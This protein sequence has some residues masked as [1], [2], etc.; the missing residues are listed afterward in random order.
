MSTDD[1][2]VETDEGQKAIQEVVEPKS[3]VSSK[4]NII[5]D[6]T[7]L[8][9]LMGCGRLTNFSFNLNLQ[10][11]GGKSN[12]LEVGSI[13]HK[14]LEVYYK[15]KIG[16]MN[17]SDAIQHGMAAGEL[18]IRGCKYCTD[19]EP[20]SELPK[21][22]CSHPIN[23]YPGVKNTPP[24]STTSPKNLVGWR[25]ALDT[26]TQYFDRW[27]NDHWVPIDIEVVKGE[28]LYE[29]DNIR[30]LWKAKLD[31]IFD[32]NQGIYPVDHKTSKARRKRIKLNN[33][34]KGQCL[35]MKTRNVFINSIGFQTSLK[36]EEK[37][38]REA[39]SYSAAS[40]LEW[41]G[42]IL[43]Y[44]A[45]QLLQFA[46]SG[47]WPPNFDHCETKYG[48]CKFLQ[49]CEADPNMREEELKLHYVVGPEW[50]PTN[51]ED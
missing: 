6:A 46:E 17:T 37:F 49:V 5:F 29:D 30:I 48:T 32:T 10:P 28:I 24:D 25:N 7:V 15:N 18:W 36:P 27:K 39:M 22:S 51:D 13:V 23:E 47:Y 35:L 20:T 1:F 40:L 31:G 45:Y 12:S 4:Q 26:C 43:P 11:M 42:E 19:F 41:Q 44:Y 8:S 38:T 33:Q 21:P 3:I 14:V 9:T 16:G 34:F 50:N 2:L